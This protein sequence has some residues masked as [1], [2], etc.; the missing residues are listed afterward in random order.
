M[1]PPRTRLR[2]WNSCI[3]NHCTGTST[4]NAAEAGCTFASDVDA[5]EDAGV[6]LR[7]VAMSSFASSYGLLAVVGAVVVAVLALLLLLVALPVPE[8]GGASVMSPAFVCPLCCEPSLLQIF[9][10]TSSSRVLLALA[11]NHGANW[12][13]SSGL[14]VC[15]TYCRSIRNNCMLPSLKET[16]PS[17]PP[18]ARFAALADLDGFFDFAVFA[19]G[20]AFAVDLFRFGA[21]DADDA[22]AVCADLRGDAELDAFC[23]SCIM[24]VVSLDKDMASIIVFREF[25]G[26]ETLSLSFP[27]ASARHTRD[28]FRA[29]PNEGNFAELMDGFDRQD[30]NINV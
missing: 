6:E 26:I 7:I 12:R 18:L 8:T 4:G 11:C 15:N 23:A 9:A 22:R 13:Y 24:L 3:S 5:E 25:Y 30:S 19:A 16:A 14:D 21:D 28:H 17:L 2:F 1:V 29:V 20:P 27:P 10:N